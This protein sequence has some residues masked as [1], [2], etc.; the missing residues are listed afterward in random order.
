MAIDELARLG[1]IIIFGR[2]VNGEPTDRDIGKGQC[3]MCHQ[4]TGTLIRNAGPSFTDSE[5]QTKV[6]IGLRGEIRIQDPRYKSD[7]A[8]IEAYP[9]SGRPRRILS[10]LRSHKFV[11]PVLS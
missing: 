5:E 1:E 11:P 6:P 10:I 9:G 2:V 8:F 7:F 3:A 4:V